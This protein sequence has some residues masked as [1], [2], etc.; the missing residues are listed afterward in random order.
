MNE[1]VMKVGMKANRLNNADETQSP[2]KHVFSAGKDVVV[3][4][5]SGEE[6]STAGYTGVFSH[7]LR[8]SRTR[9][10]LTG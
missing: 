3:G 4:I 10:D 5:G 6:R 7:N 1:E 9:G 2:V 8:R